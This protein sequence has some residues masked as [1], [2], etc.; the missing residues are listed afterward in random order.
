MNKC[1]YIYKHIYI[2]I[3]MNRDKIEKEKKNF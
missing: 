3:L 2:F 1:L